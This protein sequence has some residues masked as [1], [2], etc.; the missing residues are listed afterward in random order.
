MMAELKLS[1]R[2]TLEGEWLALK[3]ALLPLPVLFHFHVFGGNDASIFLVVLT[4]GTGAEGMMTSLYTTW[5][6]GGRV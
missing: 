1:Q 6:C 4:T 2:L 5:L 3:K